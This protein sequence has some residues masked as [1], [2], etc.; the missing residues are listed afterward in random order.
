MRER[1][2]IETMECV[3]IKR[4]IVSREDRVEYEKEYSKKNKEKLNEQA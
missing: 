4:P 3:N 1:H 2:F